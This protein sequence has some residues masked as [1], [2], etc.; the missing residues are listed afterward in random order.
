[1]T[2]QEWGALGELVGGVAV[3]ATLIYLAVQTRQARRSAWAQAPQ[4]ISDGYRS[5]ISAPREDAEL[6]ELLIRATH[7]WSNLSQIDQFRVH[8]WWADK[9]VHLDAV[10]TLHDQGV[11]DELRTRAWVD[12]SLGLLG[13]RG[14]AEWWSDVKSVFTPQVRGELD[15]RLED[16]STLPAAWSE[17]IPFLRVEPVDN[18]VGGPTS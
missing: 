12:D 3:I 14:G 8:C 18:E 5:W 15:R 16:R 4:W 1:M 6:A 9:I 11:I 17:T 2:L 7:G 10:L 13:T